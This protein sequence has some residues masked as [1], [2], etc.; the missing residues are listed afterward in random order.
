MTADSRT[1]LTLLGA[2]T[3][4]SMRT[5]IALGEAAL[6]F[7]VRKIDLRHTEQKSTAFLALNPVG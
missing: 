4:N 6:E 7:D 5:A 1:H 2:R 3:N